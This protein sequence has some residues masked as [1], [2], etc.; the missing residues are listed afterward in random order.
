MTDLASKIPKEERY[1][2]W[3]DKNNDCNSTPDELVMIDYILLTDGLLNMVKNVSIYHGYYEKCDTL[4][5]D[6]YPVIV[7]FNL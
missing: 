3:W 4:E 5:S 1:T 7:D 2:N 6:H